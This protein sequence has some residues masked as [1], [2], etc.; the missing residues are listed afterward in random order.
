MADINTAT[1]AELQ[2][3]FAERGVPARYTCLFCTE[4]YDQGRI[5]PDGDAFQ[6]AARA[7]RQHIEQAHAGVFAALMALGPGAHGLSEAQTAVLEGTFRG[8]GDAQ[9]ALA[10]GGRAQSTVRNHR[11]QL[12]RKQREAR[13]F[14][15]LTTLLDVRGVAD[16]GFV[17]FHDALPVADDRT[18]ITLPEAE[19]LLQKYFADPG[20]TTLSRFPKQ[21]K[22]KL[23][24]LQH[25]VQRFEPGH[26]YAEREVNEL[27][28]P[29]YA[30]FAT[31]RRYL[32][33]YRFLDRR[34]DGSAYWRAAA[35]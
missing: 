29:A 27:L 22:H 24:V 7:A 4:T 35:P 9:I 30:D 26:H 31:L 1:L 15:A 20:R 18:V 14:L 10:L 6:D 12:R 23:V 32:I 28:K 19:K 2:Q 34:P 5:Y 17:T 33:E 3:G 11:F 25:L 13:V 8:D 16:E 21:E